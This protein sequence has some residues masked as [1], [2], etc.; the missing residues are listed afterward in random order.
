MGNIRLKSD[1]QEGKD[2]TTPETV[3][4]SEG[5]SWNFGENQTQ[6]LPDTGTNTT[7]ASNATVKWGTATQQT[8]APSVIADVEGIEGR[9]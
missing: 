5:Y 8:E 9:S 1:R 7:L 2:Y 4:D 3:I 6:V